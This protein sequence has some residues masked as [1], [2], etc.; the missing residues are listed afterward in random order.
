MVGTALLNIESVSKY[1]LD[2]DDRNVS[3]LKDVALAIGST[4]S[5]ALI[6]FRPGMI[7]AT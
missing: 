1:H 6:R 5:L 7:H 2:A 3:I 4:G